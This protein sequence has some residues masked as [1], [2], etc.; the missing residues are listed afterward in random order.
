MADTPF[1]CPLCGAVSHNPNDARHRYCGRCH[2]FVDDAEAM[3]KARR[4]IRRV[5][6]FWMNE[7]GPVLR[8]AATAYLRGESLTDE[9]VAALRAYL[10]QWM[11]GDWRGPETEA[12]RAGIDGLTSRKA[13]AAWLHAALDAGIDPL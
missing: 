12:L 3:L 1:T 6:G 5:P 13:I 8:P 11:E 4:D 9:Q 2:V 10:R 7:A